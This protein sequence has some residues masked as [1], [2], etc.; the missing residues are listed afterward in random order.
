MRCFFSFSSTSVAAP[1]LITPMPPASLARRSCSFSLSQ[2]ESVR[3]QLGAQLGDAVCD[4]L[5]RAGAVNNGG[6]VLGDRDAAGGAQHLQANLVQ[7]QADLRGDNLRTGQGRDVLQHGLAA[8]AEA[9]SL[10]GN[11]VQRAADA[12]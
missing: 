1:T 8:V 4:V 6:V 2:S 11:D 12:C 9:W 10:D 5:G 7:G 3:V